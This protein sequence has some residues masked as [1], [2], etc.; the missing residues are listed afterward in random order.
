M[1]IPVEHRNPQEH[2]LLGELDQPIKDMNKPAIPMP[3][4]DEV[5]GLTELLKE[6]P[7]IDVDKMKEINDLSEL[8][9]VM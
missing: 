2:T 1:S 5:D 4:V 9:D 3:K 7:M 6:T 8:D